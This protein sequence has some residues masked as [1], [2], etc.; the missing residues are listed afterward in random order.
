MGDDDPL[1]EHFDDL[2][3]QLNADIDT[4]AGLRSLQK[5]SDGVRWPG[6]WI[7]AAA[8]A[9]VLLGAIAG[10]VYLQDDGTVV[11]ANS[12]RPRDELPSDSCGNLNQLQVDVNAFFTSEDRAAAPATIRRFGGVA[13]LPTEKLFERLAA[14]DE[15]DYPEDPSERGGGMFY[16]TFDDGVDPAELSGNIERLNGVARVSR[17]RWPCGSPGEF[18]RGMY[19]IDLDG[20]PINSLEIYSAGQQLLDHGTSARLDVSPTEFDRQLVSSVVTTELLAA[21]GRSNAAPVS[22]AEIERA[23]RALSPNPYSAELGRNVSVD[24]AVDDESIWR[25]TRLMLERSR[26]LAEVLE[27]GDLERSPQERLRTFVA[28]QLAG[29]EV[30]VI[31]PTGAVPNDILVSLSTLDQASPS[32]PAEPTYDVAETS[33]TV[34]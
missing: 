6:R 13:Q 33:T 27:S 7:A 11:S 28:Q 22:R 2:A 20:D 19:W 31:T 30:S 10:A 17:I 25:N 32:A 5:R 3:T 21:N 26:G 12:G 4:A 34:P 15:F 14:E 9:T 24:E 18:S 29:M 8:A 23:I 1:R 16:V